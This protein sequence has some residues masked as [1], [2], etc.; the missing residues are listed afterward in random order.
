MCSVIILHRAN[1]SL[2][3]NEDNMKHWKCDHSLFRIEHEHLFS[4]SQK[5]SIL[6]HY[7]GLQ[8]V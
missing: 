5:L 3:V 4:F 2:V 6:N 1:F 7:Y 8:C